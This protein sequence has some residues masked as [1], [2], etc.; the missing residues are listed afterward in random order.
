M[1]KEAE[2]I[3]RWREKKKSEGKSS[4]TVLLSQDA[5]DIL[6]EEKE[7]TGESYAVIM[8]KALMNLKRQGYT[9][10][11]FRHFPRQEEIFPQAA[12]QESHQPVEREKSPGNGGQPLLLIDDLVN[13]PTMADLE[14]EQSAK[15]Q[16]GLH[17]FKTN[18][19]FISRLLRSPVS[20]FGRKK[21]WFK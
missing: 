14:R 20:P 11:V 15:D 8:E 3:R 10:P 2:R 9:P 4:F 21:K 13:Y 17:D 18:D 1:K 7:K 12:P 19:G 5:R 6:N 16:S